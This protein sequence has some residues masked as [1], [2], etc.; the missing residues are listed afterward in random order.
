M[1]SHSIAGGGGLMLHVREWGNPGARPILFIHGWSQSHLCWSKQFGS[2]LADEFHLVAM[3][4]RGHGQSEAPL[5]PPSYTNG[6]LWA[7]DV[8][9]VIEDLKLTRPVLV[10]WSYGGLIICDYLRRYGDGAVGSIN[11]VGAAVG[12]GQRWFGPRIG[13]GFLTHAPPACSPDQAVALNGPFCMP[14]PRCLSRRRTSSWRWGG[15]CWCTLRF[16]PI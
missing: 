2:P 4:I 16:A 9:R 5:D 8:A 12:I 13:P 3:D 11:F 1:K 6:A 14:A 15:A 7:D 10:G